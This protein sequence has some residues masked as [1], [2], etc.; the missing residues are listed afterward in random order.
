MIDIGHR[1]PEEGQ[2][3][4]DEELANRPRPDEIFDDATINRWRN[5]L[6]I[7]YPNIDESLMNIVLQAYKYHPEIVKQIN[8][9][10]RNG[11]HKTDPKDRIQGGTVI[12]DFEV[13]TNLI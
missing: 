6:K 12:Q 9:E 1:G 10:H 5:Q 8:D 2:V 3:I 13:G 4:G 11:M 7:E